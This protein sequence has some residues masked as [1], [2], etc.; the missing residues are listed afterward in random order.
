M[1]KKILVRIAGLLENPGGP[2]NEFVAF[3][4][5]VHIV[6]RLEVIEIAVADHKG[7]ALFEQAIQVLMDGYIAW[8]QGQRI[9]VARRLDLQAGDFSHEFLAAAHAF[10]LPILGHQKAKENV[11][12]I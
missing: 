12:W 10:V 8:Q 3:P 5:P 2:L 1:A 9:G 7:K 6:I 4:V 11:P